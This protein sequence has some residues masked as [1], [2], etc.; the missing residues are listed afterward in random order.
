MTATRDEQLDQVA[1]D[2][3]PAARALVHAVRNGTRDDVAQ[4][5]NWMRSR[6]QRVALT[7]VLAAMVDPATTPAD[8]LAWLQHHRPGDRAPGWAAG[9][10]A[11]LEAAMRDHA[12]T[13]PTTSAADTHPA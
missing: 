5:L 8:A 1:A 6:D 11:R 7:V 2:V 12:R 9:N 13:T 4:V 3:I 10:R